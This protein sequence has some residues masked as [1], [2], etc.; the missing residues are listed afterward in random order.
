MSMWE[1]FYVKVRGQFERVFLEI[2]MVML[3]I[4]SLLNWHF[5]SFKRVLGVSEGYGGKQ[6][7]F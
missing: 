3:L 4:K 1:E 6:L 7:E 2:L 5:L